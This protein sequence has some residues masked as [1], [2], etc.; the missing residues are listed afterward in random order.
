M[1][2]AWGIITCHGHVHFYSFVLEVAGLIVN[3][4]SL[5][6][7]SKPGRACP[8]AAAGEGLPFALVS[9]WT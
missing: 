9:R 6:L 3:T 8:P 4:L 7:P 1:R 5:T 2:L